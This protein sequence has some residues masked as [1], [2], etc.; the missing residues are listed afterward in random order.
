MIIQ[1]QKLILILIRITAFVVLCPGFSFKGLPNTVK[2]ALSF[3]LSIIVYFA[4]PDIEIIGGLLQFFLLTIRETLF[5]LALGYISQLIYGIMEIAGQLIDFQVGFSMGSVYDPSLGAT[6][7][8]YGKT[9]YWLSISIFFLLD[10]HHRVIDALIKSFE[11]V[12]ITTASFQGLTVLNII[13][14]FS[15]VFELALN[16]AAPII[17]V[18][19]V[20]D[21]VLG[22][23]SKTVPQ[24]N[25]LMLGMPMKS[26]ISFFITML[27]LSWLMKSIGNG[28]YLIPEYLE[29]F[30]P[31]FG[32]M[33][34]M[35]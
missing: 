26:M 9:Y 7:S 3:S 22:I 2:I 23:I 21:V 11:Y 8:N 18:V 1:L 13:N 20:T 15:R 4:L 28:L 32:L 14:L 27:M 24:I 29:N 10:I 35:V 25:V 34:F 31:L 5:G 16:L 17:I 6:A 19:L 12:P 33:K 30:I